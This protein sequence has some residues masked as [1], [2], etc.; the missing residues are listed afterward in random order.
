MIRYKF[1]KEIN[2][3]FSTALRSRVRAYFREQELSSHANTNMVIKSV[4]ALSLYLGSYIILIGTGVTT[5]PQQF[6]LWT[7]MGI[8]TVI[9]GTSVMHDSLHGSYSKDRFINRLMGAS[10]YLIGVDPRVWK[11][12]HNTL[13]H[14]YTNIEHADE[15]IAPRYVLR[16]SPFQ[17]R[18]WF[19]RYQHI[20]AIFFYS[21]FTLLWISLKDIF[22][23]INYRREGLVKSDRLFWQY[24]SE[25]I[26]FKGTYQIVFLWVPVFVLDQPI[27]LTFLMF[28]HMH[29]VTG[30]MLSVIFQ[31]AHVMPTSHFIEQ[32]EKEVEENW[33]V[34][35]LYTTSNYAMDS[36]LIT[37]LFGGL[38]YQ[39]EHHLFPNV[40]HVHYPEISKIV[41]ATAQE[42]N[43]PYYAQ[44]TMWAAFYYHFGMLKE[45]GRSDQVG[46]VT[47][48]LSEAKILKN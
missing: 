28:V 42:Y 45:L 34:H 19:H 13:H 10:A 20:Y 44:P 17:E 8:G 39:V 25:Q 29:F 41:R 47:Y 2:R 26:F 35:Q 12:Q 16:F 18:Y 36:K 30:F 40:C 1:S 6:I 33:S 24:L 32:E 5:L 38:N 22:K 11:I 43:L 9:I 23:L 27:W 7:L 37:W 3:D 48:P 21:I 31:T 15:D 4:F 14:T 46:I